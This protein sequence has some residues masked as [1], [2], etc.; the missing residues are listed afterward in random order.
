MLE[1]ILGVEEARKNLGDLIVRVARKKQ[2]VVITRRTKEKA[3]LVNYEEYK[4][5]EEMAE[6]VAANDVSLALKR[7]RRSVAAEGLSVETVEM[8]IREVRGR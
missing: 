5:L 7:I 4:K 8:S 1:Y 2:P 3:V 6:S